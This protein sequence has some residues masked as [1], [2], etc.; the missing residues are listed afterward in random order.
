[1]RQL[2]LALGLDGVAQIVEGLRSPDCALVLSGFNGRTGY[3]I[4]LAPRFS[5]FTPADFWIAC[6]AKVII[7]IRAGRRIGVRRIS[8][9]YPAS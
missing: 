3:G 9:L 5:L 7:W 1:M 8:K 4:G 6:A 2:L